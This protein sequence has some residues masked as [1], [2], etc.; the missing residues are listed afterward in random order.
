MA[1][2]SHEPDV[3]AVCTDFRSAAAAAVVESV[4]ASW[5]TVRVHECLPHLRASRL[6]ACMAKAPFIDVDAW[7]P[8]N[9]VVP[10][11]CGAAFAEGASCGCF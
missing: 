2:V 11:G 7:G 4:D 10:V 1:V 3:G 6:P 9:V 8:E 5:L